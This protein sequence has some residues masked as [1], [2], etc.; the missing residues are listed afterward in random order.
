MLELSLI[1]ILYT[2]VNKIN[3]K[4]RIMKTVQEREIFMD[5]SGKTELGKPP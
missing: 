4:E 2:K 3:Q 1:S 5:L